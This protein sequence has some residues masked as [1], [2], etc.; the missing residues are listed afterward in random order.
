[1]AEKAAARRASLTC[2]SSS[3]GT[4]KT[5]QLAKSMQNKRR[6]DERNRLKKLARDEKAMRREVD[7]RAAKD[8]EVAAEAERKAAFLAKINEGIRGLEAKIDEFNDNKDA[9]LALI[10][11]LQTRYSRFIV[12]MKTGLISGLKHYLSNF[13]LFKAIWKLDQP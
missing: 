3:M 5:P 8:D 11:E 6:D 12:I 1:M 9:N 7:L 10:L 2:S 4:L 13:F